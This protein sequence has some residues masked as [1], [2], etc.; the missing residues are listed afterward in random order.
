MGKKKKIKKKKKIEIVLCYI[1][2][3][4][5]N[6]TK[7]TILFLYSLYNLSMLRFKN[8]MNSMP[9]LNAYFLHLFQIGQW[10]FF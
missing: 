4:K 3:R 2:N 6:G 7:A 5:G 10:L 9:E 1:Q 8:S